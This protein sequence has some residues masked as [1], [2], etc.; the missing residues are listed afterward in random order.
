MS[1]FA[2]L[3]EN[4]IVLRVIV[5]NNNDILDKDGKEDEIIGIAFCKKLLGG[6]WV[7][8]SYNSNFRKHFAGK[9]YTYDENLDAFISPKPFES[10]ILNEETCNWEA[11]ISFPD[12][13][14]Q[15]MWNE[16]N[17]IWVEVVK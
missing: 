1:H 2:E 6:N 11:P 16:E 8:T 13:G 5:V 4:N 14:K 9:G 7:Q 10:W 15:Y 17:Q 12:D 3:D